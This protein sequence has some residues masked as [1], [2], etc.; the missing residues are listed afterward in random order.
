MRRSLT[1]VEPDARGFR[2]K[3]AKALCLGLKAS[4]HLDAVVQEK[5][6]AAAKATCHAKEQEWLLCHLFGYISSAS[7][8]STTSTDDEDPPIADAY[9]EEMD[10]RAAGRKGKGPKW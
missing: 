6:T 4:E 10:H 3:N 1:T 2:R 7:E 8:S 5:E 9:T